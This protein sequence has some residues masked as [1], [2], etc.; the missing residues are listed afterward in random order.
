MNADFQQSVRCGE[1]VLECETSLAI[2]RDP[3]ELVKLLADLNER[4]QVDLSWVKH[5]VGP[6][7]LLTDAPQ[8]CSR[9]DYPSSKT[10]AKLV[11]K[12]VLFM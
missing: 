5:L 6:L 10:H 1:S 8:H 12:G 9:I 11:Q 4:T 2:G 3:E 7:V